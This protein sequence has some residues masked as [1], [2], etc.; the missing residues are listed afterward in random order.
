MSVLTR[1]RSAAPALETA[2]PQDRP[3]PIVD[4]VAGP[5][6]PVARR[7]GWPGGRYALPYQHDAA[8]A[9]LG[10]AWFLLGTATLVVVGASGSLAPL[11]VV[12]GAVAAAAGF[13]SAATWRQTGVMANRPVAAAGALA[14]AG[15]ALVAPGWVG[16]AA[17]GL[18]VAAVLDSLFA[19]SPAR[20]VSVA[21]TTAACGAIPG[22][23]VA[24]LVFVADAE[25]YAAACLFAL[26]AFYD[27]G[28]YV[29]G[30][31]RNPIEGPLWGLLSAGIVTFVFA[32][33]NVPPFNE[34]L[35]AWVFGGMAAVLC[36]VGQLAASALLPAAG[37]PAPALRRLD[38]LLVAAPVWAWAMWSYLGL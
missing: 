36:P 6:T 11:A 31:S 4:A 34:S 30:S 32:M 28:D 38:S 14:M 10:V 27:A 15:A 3:P 20:A 23:A 2:P 5:S 7:L 21:G 9:L 33:W 37:A 13:Q 35:P 12:W 26:I 24:S 22:L 16:V 29:N 8:R 17:A 25:I 19:G 18:V 1:P